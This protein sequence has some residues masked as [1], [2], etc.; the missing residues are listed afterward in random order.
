MSGFTR[1]L[2]Q[3]IATYLNPR[4]MQ[5]IKE[6]YNEKYSKQFDK[7]IYA[8]EIF[9]IPRDKEIL[10]VSLSAINIHLKRLLSK[11][12]VLFEECSKTCTAKINNAETRKQLKQLQMRDA[13]AYAQVCK[14]EKVQKCIQFVTLVGLF[15]TKLAKVNKLANSVLNN[16]SIR[17]RT[18]SQRKSISPN[19]SAASRKINQDQ[20][21]ISPN[22]SRV[23]DRR[24]DRSISPDSSENIDKFKQ[25]YSEFMRMISRKMNGGRTRRLSKK[26]LPDR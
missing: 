5:Q 23:S 6:K 7:L 1:K 18:S 8:L 22:I 14:T 20:F 2:S 12:R 16:K 25:L 13:Y 10:L 11:I 3:I 15:E 26:Y 17:S 24:S 9:E 21:V 4:D 19:I